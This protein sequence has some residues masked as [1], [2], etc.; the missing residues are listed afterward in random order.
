MEGPQAASPDVV[1]S[2]RRVSQPT[3]GPAPGFWR[4]LRVVLQHRYYRRLLAT[5]VTSR[6]GDGF[7][8][9]AA[10]TYVLFDPQRQA[11]AA[12]YALAF[13]VIYL[14]YSLIGPF[15]GIALDR[16]QR[17]QVLLA[18]STLRAA[19]AALLA[20]LLLGGTADWVFAVLVLAAFGLNRFFLAG[21]GASIPRVVPMDELVMANAVTPTIGTLFFSAGGLAAVSLRTA[22][23]GAGTG[24]VT[25]VAVAAACFVLAALLMLRLPRT[26]LGPGSTDDIPQ[27]SSAVA[28]VVLGLVGA[29]RHLTERFPAGWALLVMAS[30]RFAF[31]FVVAQTVVLFR[32]YFFSPRE[33]D[34]ALGAIATSGLALAAGIGLAVVLTP[35]ATRRMPKERWMVLLLGLGATGM[36]LP[37]IRLEIWS[38]MLAGA[39]LGLSSQGV[40]ICVDSL[41]QQ[42]TADDVRGRAFS[43]Y[44]MLFNVA[45][46]TSAV[47]AA[48]VLPLDGASAAAFLAVALLMALIA[49]V[50]ARGTAS[51]RYR[52]LPSPASLP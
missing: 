41:V 22:A 29:V 47:T 5:A 45:L 27:V 6:L 52:A 18:S 16:W 23:G 37:A 43:L 13:T 40:K 14:P 30:H 20:V 32:N 17:R 9:A 50:Y 46:V 49:A 26:Q 7:L 8:F 35:I 21:V 33:V 25:L 4:D 12:G 11:T 28:M 51:A 42:W 24:D 39:L 36:L 31:G 10:G 34:A 44:D 3:P 1:R 15:A 38:V 48:L 19:T 2:L